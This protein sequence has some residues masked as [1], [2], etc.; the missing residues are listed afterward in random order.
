MGKAWLAAVYAL[1]LGAA[2]ASGWL[3]FNP[4]VVSAAGG[5]ATCAGG[6]VARCSEGATRCVCVDYSGCTSYFADGTKSEDKC[7]STEIN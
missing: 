6:T 7:D 1:C 5:T 4:P 3:L 2:A